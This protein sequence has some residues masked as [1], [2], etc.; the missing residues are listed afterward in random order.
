MCNLISVALFQMKK[1]KRAEKILETIF[2]FLKL[3]VREHLL[4]K[5]LKERR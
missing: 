5:F 4:Q 3:H 1:K 2:L